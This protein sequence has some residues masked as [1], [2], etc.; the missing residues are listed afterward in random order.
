MPSTATITAFYSFTA[1]TQIKSAEMN[2]NFSNFRGHIIAVDPNTATAATTNTYDLGASDRYWRAGYITQVNCSTVSASTI[3]GTSINATTIVGTSINATS[4][5]GTTVSATSMSTT[6]LT[7]SSIVTTTLT[8]TDIRGISTTSWTPRI[9]GSSSTG[10]ATYIAQMGRRTRF[11]NRVFLDIYVAWTSGSGT[12]GL[13]IGNLPDPTENV[14]NY[15]ASGSIGYWDSVS[16]T[17]GAAHISMVVGQAVSYADFYQTPS[18][19]GV[20][21]AIPYD[22]AGLIMCSIS[23]NI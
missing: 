10:T 2:S 17:A 22:A 5:V 6:T 16:V 3:V 19:G 23:Y 20:A 8:V 13:R 15:R 21:Q 18:G 1:G 11:G 4:I 7:A 9:D 14:S 12:G